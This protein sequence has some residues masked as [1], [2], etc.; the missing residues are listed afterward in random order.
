MAEQILWRSRVWVM[1]YRELFKRW[2]LKCTTWTRNCHPILSLMIEYSY[3]AVYFLTD[4]NITSSYLGKEIWTIWPLLTLQ[5]WRQFWP[6][7]EERWGLKEILRHWWLWHRLPR[8][9]R[10]PEWSEQN[11]FN[12]RVRIDGRLDQ[13]Y[14]K[15]C[16]LAGRWVIFSLYFSRSSAR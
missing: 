7:T 10:S 11:T 16:Q 5:S 8:I 13:T 12:M 6:C 2:S 3:N 1:V 14:W 4:V 9:L 15:T